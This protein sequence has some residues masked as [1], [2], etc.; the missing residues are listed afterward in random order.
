MADAANWETEGARARPGAPVEHHPAPAALQ[1]ATWIGALLLIAAAFV[2]FGATL[3]EVHTDESEVHFLARVGLVVLI[4][5]AIAVV[6]A[7]ALL[8]RLVASALVRR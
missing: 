5:V 6:G 1:A 8:L 3:V 2:C 4:G 7:V